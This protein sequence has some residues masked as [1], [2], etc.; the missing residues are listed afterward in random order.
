MPAS[1]EAY[2]RAAATITP[3]RGEDAVIL[4]PL[5]PRRVLLEVFEALV[6]YGGLSRETR[7]HLIAAFKVSLL[8]GPLERRVL[9]ALAERWDGESA[10]GLAEALAD[11][12]WEPV[13]VVE[14][15][16]PDADLDVVVA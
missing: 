13:V 5:D 16:V 4:T 9:A 11:I 8:D 14:N 12:V 7:R 1:F 10:R 2:D 6:S 3:V 15:D